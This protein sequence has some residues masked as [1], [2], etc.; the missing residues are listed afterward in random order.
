MGK[1]W[2]LDTG[3][4][5]TGAEMVPLDKVLDDSAPARAPVLAPSKRQRAR[6]PEPRQ[7]WRFKVVDAMTRQVLSE[8]EGARATIDLL[9]AVRSVVDVSIYA[10]DAEASDWRPLSLRERLTLWRLRDREKEAPAL[11]S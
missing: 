11:E 9:K 1:A 8:D 4:K 6:E 10:W 2:I 7:P 3:T 5:G